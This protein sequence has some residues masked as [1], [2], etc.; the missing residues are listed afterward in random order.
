MRAFFIIALV[1]LCGVMTYLWVDT[2]KKSEE[3]GRKDQARITELS[4]EI[5][6]KDQRLEEQKGVNQELRTELASA[7][8]ELS[9]TAA[10]LATVQENLASV[11]TQAAQANEAVRQAEAELAKRATEITRLQGENEDLTQ[12]MSVLN[13][14]IVGLE[15][16]IE[17]SEKLLAS[18]QGDRAFLLKEIQRM[19]SE[20]VE[21]ERKFNDLALLKEQVSQ[22][23]NELNVA[24]RVELMRRGRYAGQ[25]MKGAQLLRRGDFGRTEPAEETEAFDLDVELRQDGDPSVVNPATNGVTPLD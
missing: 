21:L 6:L 5:I 16:K 15:N 13:E 10:V 11:E 8:D 4:D 20:K 9:E 7:R 2:D 3:K 1:I 14:R 23:Q 22:L 24:R 18:A 19:Q 12:R 17:E 25:T